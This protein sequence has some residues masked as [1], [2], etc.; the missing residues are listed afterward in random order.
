MVHPVIPDARLKERTE[1]AK[2]NRMC[3]V[4]S[5]LIPDDGQA[6][7]PDTE[8]EEIKYHQSVT[9]CNVLMLDLKKVQ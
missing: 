9:Y 7:E 6:T 2:C 5:I 3:T 8:L 4:Y 1:P